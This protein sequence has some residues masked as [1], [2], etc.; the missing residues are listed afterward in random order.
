MFIPIWALVLVVCVVAYLLTL[1]TEEC[2]TEVRELGSRVAGALA[3]LLTF[4]LI[5]G[6]ALVAWRLLVA[7]KRQ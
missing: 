4:A 5:S 2:R 3:M 7:N 1:D 6:M